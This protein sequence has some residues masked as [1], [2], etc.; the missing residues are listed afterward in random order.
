MK[1]K[2]ILDCDPGHDDAV[3]IMLAAAHDNIEL[4]GITC[5]AGNATLDNT[6]Q[7]ALKICSLIGQSN[8]PIYSGAE[9]PLIYD[10]VTA[11]HVHGKSGLDNDGENIKVDDNYKIQKMS[12]E[13]F[14]IS[15]CHAQNESIYL[16]PVGPLT[17]I[18]KALKKDPSIKKK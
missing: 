9:K 8:I 1:K 16:C 3:A 14:I 10:L 2:I 7:N 15:A 12:A 18:A 13:D 6:K 4:L 17:N 11:E 5:V